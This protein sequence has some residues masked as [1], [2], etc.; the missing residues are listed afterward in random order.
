[1]RNTRGL[2]SA[3]GGEAAGGEEKDRHAKAAKEGGFAFAAE[4]DCQKESPR[5]L[6]RGVISSAWNPRFENR[7]MW[8]TPAEAV[9]S[10]YELP[11]VPGIPAF[12][13]TRGRTFRSM[14]RG[15]PETTP[16]TTK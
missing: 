4:G 6:M 9:P 14:K 13:C 3:D 7:E 11:D 2:G 16:S 8:G 1:M 12:D 15:A 10:R 5:E